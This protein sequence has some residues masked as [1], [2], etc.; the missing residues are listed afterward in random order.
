MPKN[1]TT[2][3]IA[4]DHTIFRKALKGFLTQQRNIDVIIEASNGSELLEELKSNSVDILLTD[5]YMPE[6]NGAEAVKLVKTMYPDI[7]VIVM[8]MHTDPHMINRLLDEGIYAYISKAEEPETLLQAISC[9]TENRIYKNKLFTEALLRQNKSD[10][11]ASDK[12]IV[13]E[14][15]EK[16]ILQ[17]MWEDKNNKEIADEVFLGIRSIEKIRQDM[18]EKLGVKSTIGLLKYGLINNIIEVDQV[19]PN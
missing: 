18:K 1:L 16:R 5:L 4:E 11:T 13:L 17:L 7:K 3:A 9:A 2:I 10:V 19:N 8:S 6:V 14:E 15:R 12:H